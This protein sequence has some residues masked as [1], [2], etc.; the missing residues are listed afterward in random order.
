M[1]QMGFLVLKKIEEQELNKSEKLE[2]MPNAKEREG[3]GML[4]P[5]FV[6]FLRGLGKKQE[7]SSS[8]VKFHMHEIPIDDPF[9]IVYRDKFHM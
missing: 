3:L 9:T 6:D 2:L 4:H 5:T 8:I 1:D 7:G